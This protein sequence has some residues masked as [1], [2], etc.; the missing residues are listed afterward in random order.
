MDVADYLGVLR[1]RWLP[2]VVCLVAGVAGAVSITR[3]TPETYRSSVRLFVNIPETRGVQESLQGVELTSGLLR[4]YAEIASSRS[5]AQRVI[6]ELELEMSAATLTKK[7]SAVPTEDTLL[8]TISA[9]DESPALA[10]ALANGAADVFIEIVAELESEREEKI[11]ARVID[12]AVESSRP[13]SPRPRRNLVAGMGLGLGL[14]LA[15]AFLLE[16]LDRTIKTPDQAAVAIGR[17]LLAVVP[18]RRNKNELVTVGEGS[19][20]AGEAYRA[21]RTSLRFLAVETPVHSILVTSPS[22]GE[23]KTTTAANLAVVFAQ[24][25]AR[26]VIVDADLRRARV[27]GVFGVEGPGLTAVLTGQLSM[28]DALVPWG[29]NLTVL[30]AGELPPNPAELV[31]SQAMARALSEL[32]Q[33]GLADVVIVDAPPIVPVTDA[34]AL[35]TQVQSVVMV[36]RAGRTRRDMAEEA[37]RRLDVVG[38]DVVGCVLNAV[39]RSGQLQYQQDYRYTAGKRRA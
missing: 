21:L 30:P 35:S 5:A 4:S 2:I 18:R 39:P 25:G 7:L 14:G 28:S 27:G 13:T 31:G 38:A 11:E 6:D 36:V 34:V 33:S 24:S 1:R 23:G 32:D 3:N 26:V 8:I 15:A 29:P 12:G 22:P 9:T 10:A 37:V 20:V 19:D 16:A 17:P